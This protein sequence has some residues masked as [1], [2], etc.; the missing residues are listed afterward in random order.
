[1]DPSLQPAEMTVR[2]GGGITI[3]DRRDDKEEGMETCR[4]GEL[5]K[6]GGGWVSATNLQ[7]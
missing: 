6:T 2:G 1:M 5:I 4:V 3:T 7:R